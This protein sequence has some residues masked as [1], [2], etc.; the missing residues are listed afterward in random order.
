MGHVD[1]GAAALH[2]LEMASCLQAVV[3]LG[4]K[5]RQSVLLQ[6]EVP[7][8]FVDE[9]DDDG[10][11]GLGRLGQALGAVKN[12]AAHIGCCYDCWVPRVQTLF[13]RSAVN[14]EIELLRS[15][16]SHREQQPLQAYPQVRGVVR[17]SGEN[18]AE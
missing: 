15:Q 6:E 14:S 5:P 2:Q 8:G 1:L 13:I 12:V 7:Y 18:V 16:R 17:V 9:L 3:E 11:R 4:P 10:P